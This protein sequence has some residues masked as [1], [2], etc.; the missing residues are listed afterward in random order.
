M[1]K[2]LCICGKISVFRPFISYKRETVFGNFNGIIIAKCVNC[3]ILK[4][5]KFP[6][7]FNPKK[8]RIGMYEKQKLLFKNLFK[9]VVKSVG[10]YFKKGGV[11]D[12]GC[13]S[14]LLLGLLRKK[15]YEIRGI[16]P[17]K[18]AYQSAKKTFGKRIFH[19][20]LAE[21]LKTRAK[22][23]FDI[24]I[25][26][27]V[28]EH[29]SDINTEIQL[30]R[31]ILKHKGLLVIGVPNTDNIIF[32]LRKKYW[33]PLMPLEHIWHFSSHYLTG[34]LKRQGFTIKKVYYDNDKRSDYPLVKRVYFILLSFI[35]TMLQTGESALII[36][37][38]NPSTDK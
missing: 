10:K 6:A 32:K 11:L 15:G 8:S 5:V 17:D 18:T 3:G 21:Y 7:K 25:Y 2:E 33:E 20:T 26:N 1:I 16:E 27:H 9:P 12:V 24:I 36:S 37:Q 14:G 13:S 28:L 31:K 22:R 4:T 38:Y 29:I 30:V 19:G 23:K 35:N 34:F